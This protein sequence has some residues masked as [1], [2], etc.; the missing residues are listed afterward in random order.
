[1]YVV[2]EGVTNIVQQQQRREIRE[3]NVCNKKQ[4]QKQNQKIPSR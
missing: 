4:K 3:K 2:N 1:M